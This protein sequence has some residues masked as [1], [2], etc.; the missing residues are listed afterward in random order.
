MVGSDQVRECERN[1]QAAIDRCPVIKLMFLAMER[2]GCRVIPHRHI[3]CEPC[4]NPALMGGLDQ[5]F[6]QILICSNNCLGPAKTEKILLH[7]LVHLYDHC[8]A[9][10]DLP[11]NL[12]HLAC[13][14]IRASNLTSKEL[15]DKHRQ[16]QVMDSA[17]ISVKSV[18]GKSHEVALKAVTSVF[19]KCYHDLE[20]VGRMIKTD[21]DGVLA[22]KEYKDLI[23]KMKK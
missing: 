9:H 18:T 4:K 13:T 23:K 20:P 10:L 1:V 5:E 12:K 6:N 14:E 19:E 22:L 21:Q 8:T 11:N 3:V 16:K 15:S 7:E 2:S 17:V